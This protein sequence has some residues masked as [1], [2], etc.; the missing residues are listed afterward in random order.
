MY[1][2]TQQKIEGIP[3][4]RYTLICYINQDGNNIEVWSCKNLSEESLIKLISTNKDDSYTFVLDVLKTGNGPAILSDSFELLP[5]AV[6]HEI[7][8]KPKWRLFS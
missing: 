3:T 2:V 1:K 5:I 8:A 6:K 4:N 7:K